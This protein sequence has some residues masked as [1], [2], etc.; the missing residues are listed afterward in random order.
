MP[1]RFYAVVLAIPLAVVLGACHHAATTRGIPTDQSGPI[2]DTTAFRPRIL[3]IDRHS[4]RVTF[5][6]AAPAHVIMLAVVPGKTIEPVGRI[7]SDASESEAGQYEVTVAAPQA[8]T[9]QPSSWTIQDHAAYDRCVA[10]ARRSLPK[11]VVVRRDSTGKQIAETTREVDDASREIEAERRCEAATD[12]RQRPA[13]PSTDERYLVVLA[14]STP[15]TLVELLARL[16]A[17]TVTADDVSSTI[18]AIADAL[19]VG[20]KAIWSGYYTRW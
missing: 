4:N 18:S 6:L 15:M 2:G 14:S 8:T 13:M 1:S 20:R 12:R 10:A 11:K 19:Y 16:D 17:T 3:N 7:L 5:E 9:T